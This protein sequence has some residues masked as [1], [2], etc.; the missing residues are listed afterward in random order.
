MIS[1]KHYRAVIF[2]LDGTLVD[3][4]RALTTAVNAVR[5]S[6][7]LPDLGLVTVRGHVGDGV[8]KLLERVLEAEHVEDSLRM[9]FEERYDEICCEQSTT[10]GEVEATLSALTDAGI[11]MAVCT[12]KPTGFSTK[13]LDH[14]GLASHFDAIVGPDAAL[15]RKPDPKHLLHALRATGQATEDALFVG[16]MPIDIV[17]ARGCGVDVAVI[18][19][20]SSSSEVLRDAGPDALL[21][22]FSDLLSLIRPAVPS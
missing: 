22:H 21:E 14:L 15:A 7:G 16:D 8:E 13:I 12:N 1:G 6:M 17:T 20:G 2:D 4:Y 19:T 11:H 3:S 10:L 9:R 5:T 18:A